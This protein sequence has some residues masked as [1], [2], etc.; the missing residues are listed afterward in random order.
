ME[1]TTTLLALGWFYSGNLTY[2]AT[3]AQNLR[4]WFLDPVTRMEPTLQYSR[5]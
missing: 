3:A 4:T 1:T 5:K 2:A